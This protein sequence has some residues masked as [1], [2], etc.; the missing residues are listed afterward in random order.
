MRDTVE[1]GRVGKLK[2]MWPEQSTAADAGRDI[3]SS[4]LNGSARGR[5]F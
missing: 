3:G 2:S 4:Q 1:S 5:R